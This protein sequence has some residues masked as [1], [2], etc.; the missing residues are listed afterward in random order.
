[1]RKI[2]II[3]PVIVVIA[4]VVALVLFTQMSPPVS[5]KEQAC[6]DSGGTVGTELCCKS[7]DDFPGLCVVGACGCA[8]ED[9][10]KVKI[11]NCGEGRCFDGNICV[12]EVHSFGDC[13]R[14]G[15]PVMESYPRQCRTPDGRTFAEGEEHCIAPTGE[16]MSLFEA[17]QI[18]IAS[19]CG[20]R[21]KEPYY[22]FSMCNADTGTWWIDLDI[23]KEGCN[24]ACVVVIETKGASINWRCT[25]VQE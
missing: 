2:V 1:M 17:M 5:E 8:S 12:P 4:L 23:K 24:P 15:Y 9:S 10:H 19:E 13:V 3:A 18:A 6:I 7:V 16:S 25:G 14:A 21:L 11:C 22:E 20:N